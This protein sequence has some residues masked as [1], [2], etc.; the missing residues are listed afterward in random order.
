MTE[1]RQTSCSMTK[2]LFISYY[3]PPEGGTGVQR[4]AKFVRYLPEEGFLPVVLAGP[5][6]LRFGS[7]QPCD[8]S[9]N[10][11]ANISVYRVPGE[12]PRRGKL[13]QRLERW[14]SLPT[15]FSRWWVKSSLKLAEKTGDQARLVYAT[16]SPFESAQA[17]SRISAQLGIPWV[18][19][20]RDPWALDEVILYP[21]LLHRKVDLFR[22]RRV[23]STASLVVMNTPEAM[24]VLA[25]ALPVLAPR[26]V[27][28]TNGVDNP[29]DGRSLPTRTHSKFRIVHSGGFST[30]TGLQ[31]RRRRFYRLLGG[32][33]PGVDILARSPLFLVKAVQEWCSQ[34]PD[35]ADNVEIVLAGKALP[36][37]H[38]LVRQSRVAHLFRFVGFVSH[39]E[40]LDLI[41]TANLLFLPMHNLPPGKRSTTIQAKMYEYIASG[42]PILAAVP[43]GDA[44]DFLAQ[45][46]N[47]FVCR[48]DDVRGMVQVLQ[49]VYTAWKDGRM[50]IEPRPGFMA[51]FDSRI[52]T[53]ALADGFRFVLGQ[54]PPSHLE[55]RHRPDMSSR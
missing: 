37:D 6:P 18:A 15:S 47:A 19:D 17:A 33:E 4:S 38:A 29:E 50:P 53:K 21:T 52:L 25:R 42:R 20:L 12:P 31:L 2:V 27:T 44:R 55:V 22:M 8:P 35:A 39:D 51:Q 9:L 16:M 34:Q 13:Q 48:P 54:S 10:T 36:E 30:G 41:R 49:N 40:S 5:E 28:I 46:G 43:D 32:A 14:F 3:F 45:S 26:L 24:K 7:F 1:A 23:L 11:P